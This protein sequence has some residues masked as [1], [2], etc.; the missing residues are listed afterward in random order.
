MTTQVTMGAQVTA[1]NGNIVSIEVP[2]GHIVKNEV[3]YVCL[4]DKRLKSEPRQ[5]N[6]WV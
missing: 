2:D 5:Q 6:L 1:V 3:A 4:G